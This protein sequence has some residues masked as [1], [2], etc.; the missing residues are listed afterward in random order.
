MAVAAQT[1]VCS[2]ELPDLVER[3][4]PDGADLSDGDLPAHGREVPCR[5]VLDRDVR[6]RPSMAGNREGPSE[7]G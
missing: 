5:G 6:H 2:K 7:M 1:W 3:G 4:L